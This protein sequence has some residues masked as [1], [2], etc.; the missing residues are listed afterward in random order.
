[1]GLKDP[2]VG[3]NSVTEFM[4]SGL[5][6]VTS[7]IASGATVNQYGFMK[8]TKRVSVW[9]HATGSGEHL[10]VGFTQNGVNNGNYLKIDGGQSFEFD[11]R[12]KN[13]FIRTDDPSDTISFSVFAELIAIDA[14]QMPLLTGSI[15]GTTFWEGV[16]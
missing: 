15:N 5:P 7:S 10:R 9:N 14:D 2:K 4:G 1:M 11:S 12:I 3:F 13:I 6:W 16:G 8:L